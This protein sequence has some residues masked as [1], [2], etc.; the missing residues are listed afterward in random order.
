[1]TSPTPAFTEKQLTELRASCAALVAT[2][3][4]PAYTEEVATWNLA[5]ELRPAVV[6]GAATAEDVVAA[7][8]WATEAGLPVGVLATGHGSAPNAEGALLINTRRMAQ[9]TIDADNATAQVGSGARMRDLTAAAAEH[10]LA[11]VQGSTGSTGAVGFTLGG[12]LGVLSRWLGM[13]SDDVL[14][15][16]VVT[17][18]G[19]LRTVDQDRHPDLFWALLGGRANL[20]IVTSYRTALHRLSTV[21]GGGVFFDGSDAAAVLHAYRAW[22]A[23]HDDRTSSSVALLRLPPDPDLPDPIRGQ[24]VVHV[25]MAHVGN[26][27]EGAWIADEIRRAA[28]PILDTVGPLPMESLDLVHLDPPGPSPIHERGLLLD[29]LTDETLDAILATAGGSGENPLVMVEVRPL[30]GAVARRPARASAVPGRQAG[31]QVF[32]VAADVPELAGAG[33]AMVQRLFEALRPWRA[34]E[35]FPSFLGRSHRPDQV[36]AAWPRQ[37]L[38][39]LLEVKRAWDPSNQFRV[40]H[41]LLPVEE[42]P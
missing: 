23:V 4:D 38:E 35:N 20:G 34:N 21:Y 8:R 2:P 5:V 37:T 25:R 10:G 40:G 30:G 42:R 29:T 16:D 33:S 15:I 17:V 27:V 39:R 13:A 22:A 12:G 41:A 11:A 14:S 3:G 24:F 31:F 7:V 19:Q 28:T 6:V 18:D 26:P 9:V 32:A 1:M 36:R